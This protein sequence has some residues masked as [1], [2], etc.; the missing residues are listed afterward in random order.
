MKTRMEAIRN[1]L[2]THPKGCTLGG[3]ATIVFIA[4]ET[5]LIYSATYKPDS[6]ELQ[7]GRCPHSRIISDGFR[8]TVCDGKVDLRKFVMVQGQPGPTIKGISLTEAQ[9]EVVMEYMDW[10]KE[11]IKEPLDP[12]YSKDPQV[13]S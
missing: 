12:M 7:I 9:F 13:V 3:F 10:I 8:I 6:S 4:F 11:K 5:W 2:R 1:A